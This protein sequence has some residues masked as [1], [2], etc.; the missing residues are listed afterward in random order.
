MAIFNGTDAVD[1]DFTG[2]AAADQ[3]SG[4][5]GDDK[6]S[7]LGGND[8]LIGGAGAD[9]MDGGDGIDTISYAGSTVGVF[10]SL[11]GVGS[12]LDGDAQGD[13]ISNVEN[14]IGS[15]GH[16][17][18][19]GNQL[20]NVIDGGIGDD[21]IHSNGGNDVLM[22]GVGDDHLISGSGA[23]TLIG[24]SGNDRVSFFGAVGVT[25]TLGVDGAQTIGKGGEAEGDKITGIEEDLRLGRR[26][27]RHRKQSRQPSLRI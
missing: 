5:G 11:F 27:Y 7:G 16:D 4:K 13:K 10:V 23:D 17:N 8:L 26:R 12:G 21:Q 25:V 22:G 9:V 6:L 15:A 2:T 1:D 14:I 19:N 20:D 18:L 24:G 3:M